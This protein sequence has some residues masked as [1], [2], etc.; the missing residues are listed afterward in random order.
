MWHCQDSIL[1]PLEF[2]IYINNL[3]NALL[4]QRRFFADDTSL[5]RRLKRKIYNGVTLLQ[6]LDGPQQPLTQHQ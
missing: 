6:N 4:N 1:G 2:L 3:P 5:F